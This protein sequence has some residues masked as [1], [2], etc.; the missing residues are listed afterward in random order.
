MRWA[1]RATRSTS[2]WI[3]SRRAWRRGSRR[4]RRLP[5]DYV[6]RV[7]VDVARALGIRAS[8]RRHPSRHQG[9][10]HPVRRARQ[11]GGGRLRDR[12]RAV[13]LHEPDRHQHG[14]RHAAVL[15]ARAGAGEATRRPGRPLLARRDAVPG[16][17]GTPAVRGRGLVRD[18]AP[19]RGGAA[20]HRRR[21]IN[22]ALSPEFEAVVLQCLAKSPDDRPGDGRAARRRPSSRSCRRGAIRRRRT[23]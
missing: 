12:A 11:R 18:R 16:G 3:S 20:A 19:A 5:E 6:L 17:D 21:A 23:R 8:R 13:G 9:R 2:S 22:P 14:G 10:Q 1:A 15:R 7:G 4:A